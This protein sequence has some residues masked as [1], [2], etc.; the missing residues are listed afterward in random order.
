MQRGLGGIIDQIVTWLINAA[1][2]TLINPKQG[3][4]PVRRDSLDDFVI[5]DTD[6]LRANQTDKGGYAAYRFDYFRCKVGDKSIHYGQ[7]G[8]EPGA[9]QPQK[10][11]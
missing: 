7:V 2:G 9:G 11:L 6:I 5:A 10:R 4:E 8:T 3:W 1:L